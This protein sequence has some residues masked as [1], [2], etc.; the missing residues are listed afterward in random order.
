M[1]SSLFN[2]L[3]MLFIIISILSILYGINIYPKG[4][5]SDQN[6]CIVVAFLSV[7][8]LI[9]YAAFF[10][11]RFFSGEDA[12][13]DSIMRVKLYG[14]N[15]WYLLKVFVAIY[16]CSNIAYIIQNYLGT[17]V[18]MRIGLWFLFFIVLLTLYLRTAGVELPG[19]AANAKK[20]ALFSLISNLI[21][22]I[23]CLLSDFI[24]LITGKLKNSSLGNWII[25]GICLFII[26]LYL[27]SSWIEKR[28]N[29]NGGK[30]LLNRPIYTENNTILANYL[31]LNGTDILGN[32]PYNYKYSISFW[33]CIHSMPP[34][35]NINYDKPTSLM[36]FGGKPDVLYNAKTNTLTVTVPTNEP[37]GTVG[38]K[39]HTPSNYIELDQYGNR[40]VYKQEYMPL[41]KWNHMVIIYNGGTMDVFMN[42][43]LVVSSIEVSPYMSY[44]VLTVGSNKGVSGGICNVIYFDKVIKG[45]DVNFLY[46]SVKNNT[47]P[48]NNSSNIAVVPPS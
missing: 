25:I 32:I 19:R 5:T 46:N 31:Q 48:I 24:N 38:V 26:S 34:S 23:P 9:I 44:D 41:Q 47:P 45:T 6:S 42:N 30:L 14:D 21:F 36:N 39:E 1:S 3:S 16:V 10:I 27:S 18:F 22:Y 11:F 15:L 4:I 7:F 33:F 17:T 20:N 37:K 28:I 43:E 12:T 40:I 2:N 35:T 8:I 29:T 13:V